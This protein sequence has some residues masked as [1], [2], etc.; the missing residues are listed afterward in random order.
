[1]KT[2]N[3]FYNPQAGQTKTG[4]YKKTFLLLL[5]AWFI[6]N[7]IQAI[8][9]EVLSDEAYYGLWGRY[10]DW[11]YF[12]HPPMVAL[13]TRI[14]SLFFNGN[15][16][17]RFMT[18]LLQLGTIILIWK[19]AGFREPDS[20]KVIIFF[21]IAFS[22]SLFSVY[23]VITSPDAPLLFFTALFL[24]A[25]KQFITDFSWKSV[26]LLSVSMAGMVYSKYHA[27]LVI[28]F[29]ILSNLKL[30][31]M[32]RL[33]CAGIF[34]LVLLSPHF[35][36]QFSH[37]FPSLRY[38]LIDRTEGFRWSFL[39]EYLPNQMAVF[40]PLTLGAAV[41]VM[42]KYKPS[43][44]FIRSLY[45]QIAG[46]I[47]FFWLT[48]V[49]GHAEPQW[50]IAC[51]IPMIII[52]S[53]K[54]NEDPGLLKFTRK[55]ILPSIAL[56][57]VIRILFMTDLRFVRY[58]A[59]SGKEEKYKTLESEAKDLPVVFNSTFPRP[60]LYSF[61]TGKEAMVIS[62]L[63]SRQTQ[64]DIWQFEKKYHNKPAFISINPKG[65]VQIYISDSLQFGGFR[66]DSLQTV[67][68]MKISFRMNETSLSPGDSVSISFSML[69]QYDY[70]I[71]FGHRQFPVE[72]Y[73]AFLKGEEEYFQRASFAEPVG[74]V[75]GGDTVSGILSAVIPDL[76]AGKYYFGISLSTMF[77]PAQNSHFVKTR[78]ENHD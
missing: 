68:R 6:I 66:T 50:T 73:M 13:L 8:F 51:S 39:L 29:V 55:Y 38:H 36:W 35:Y 45:F 48:A 60:S 64:F 27:V 10:L 16:G 19:A 58:L 42:I 28:G 75:P 41:Y 56:L 25:Y 18:I 31:R 2:N 46:F 70:D 65:N 72:V 32:Y 1:L 37:D 34:A 49:T 76:P 24:F 21:I 47:L 57:L 26:L 59:F 3:F 23:G 9:T 77:G 4:N 78:I 63:Y 69:N 20:Q 14:S 12:D 22:I 30:L 44:Q 67:N 7:L 62:S 11:G 54:I 53:E 15:L 61:F 40:N 5:L 17:I 71:D 43:G 52:L 74:I 33:W